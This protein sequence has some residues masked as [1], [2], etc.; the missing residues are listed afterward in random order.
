MLHHAC[1]AAERERACV[2]RLQIAPVARTALHMLAKKLLE[3]CKNPM[4]PHF[5]HYLF[6][7]AAALIRYGE[8]LLY[9]IFVT[10]CA[11]T[12]TVCLAMQ[13]QEWPHAKT[14][15]VSMQALLQ[16]PAC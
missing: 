4:Q 7:S 9:N 5:N 16:T 3:V 1:T 6:E 14:S 2:C 10:S 8:R 11:A 12:C 15:S 13:Q